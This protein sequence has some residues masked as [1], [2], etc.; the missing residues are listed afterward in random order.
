MG[1][2]REQTRGAQRAVLAWI[3]LLLMAVSF[4]WLQLLPESWRPV[5]TTV[6]APLEESFALV[7]LDPGHG[8]TDSG[9]MCAGAL[10]KDLTLDVAK[11]VQRLIHLQGFET[12]LTRQG[13]DY[14]S[15][16]NRAA[17]ANRQRD[18]VFISIHFNDGKLDASSGVETY[19]AMQQLEHDSAAFSSW[20]P[21]LQKTAL[22]SPNVQSQS[23]AGFIQDALV[24]RTQATNRGTK[25]EQFYVIANVRH[26]AVLVEGGFLTNK[27]DI[28]KLE[29]EDYRERMAAAI[30]EGILRYRDALRNRQPALAV[31]PPGAE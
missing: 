8:G 20:L 15:L 7:V 30:C 13:D 16:A 26:P 10:E 12:V 31:T 21:F 18:C 2:G 9:A 28:A 25:A 19:Y 14:V 29:T 17:F 3:G 1:P 27:I 5:T 6:P 24:V 22:Q 4:V 11:R 23:L